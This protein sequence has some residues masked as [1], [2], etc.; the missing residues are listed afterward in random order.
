MNIAELLSSLLYFTHSITYSAKR[1]RTLAKAIVKNA[2]TCNIKTIVEI[3]ANRVQPQPLEMLE[4][5]EM[6][7][8]NEKSQAVTRNEVV[9]DERGSSDD[10][11]TMDID[12][13]TF[14]N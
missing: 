2:A 14:E 13:C 12:Q 1:K 9:S 10:S 6:D 11:V 3:S 8:A 4:H 5:R 7:S